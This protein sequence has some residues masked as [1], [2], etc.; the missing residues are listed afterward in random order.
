MVFILTYKRFLYLRSTWYMVLVFSVYD[1]GRTSVT[2]THFLVTSAGIRHIWTCSAIAAPCPPPH[3]TG[4]VKRAILCNDK[5]NRMRQ[6][7]HRR[8][9]AWISGWAG[10]RAGGWV[11]WV[12]G[13]VRTME[14]NLLLRKRTYAPARRPALDLG[15]I[16]SLR[17][18]R[19]TE[20]LFG[21]RGGAH[22][23]LSLARRGTDTALMRGVSIHKGEQAIS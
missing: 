23:G 15:T 2:G 5:V 9:R 8:V 12:G 17:R 14:A 1:V 10:G 16:E 22:Y 13:W 3:R 11:G 6:H 20:G 19:R 21:G 7:C 4:C 18:Q